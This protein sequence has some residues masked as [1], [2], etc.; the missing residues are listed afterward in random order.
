VIGSDVEATAA[1]CVSTAVGA[2]GVASE[3]AGLNIRE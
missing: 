2:M 3:S 1:Q